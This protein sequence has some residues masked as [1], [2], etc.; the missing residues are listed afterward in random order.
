MDV[1]II[2]VNYNTANL[3]IKCIDSIYRFTE[4]L[5]FEIIVVD[6][7][8]TDDSVQ[9]VKTNYPQVLCISSNENLGFGKGNNL[10]V[11]YA[12]GE[13]LFLLNSDTLLMENSIAIL[14]D[15]F[16]KKEKELY[17][18]VIGCKLVDE[19]MQIANSGGGFP[20]VI[21]D[22]KEY[23]YVLVEKLFN[24]TFPPRDSYNFDAPFL[25]IDYVIG[26]D[27]F[28][29]KSVYDEVGG[30][31]EKYFM[32]YEESDMQIAIRKL[33][34]KCYINTRTKILHLE[35]GST[36]RRK[37]SSFKRI[38]LQRSR[39]YYFKKN[40]NKHYNLYLIIDMLLNLTRLFNRRYSFRENLRFVV[41]NLR[42]Y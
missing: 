14:H 16:T 26:A 13:F 40:D 29:R 42:S 6:N 10:G 25:E 34:L 4:S 37:F 3:L 7:K 24:H 30:F 15:F 1:S 27:M 31:D 5:E 33:G 20:L 38:I 8:S 2:L 9:V 18:G 11:K 32:Y 28:L 21:N 17:L 12:R 39:N 41:E 22:L 35:G 19:Q 36:N 23:Y